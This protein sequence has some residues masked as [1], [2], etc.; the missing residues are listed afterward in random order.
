MYY[1]VIFLLLSLIAV[2][3]FY[4][5]STKNYTIFKALAFLLLFLTSGLRYE[6]AVDWVNYKRFF[7]NVDY[8][9]NIFNYGFTGFFIKYPNEPLFTLLNSLVRTFTDNVQVLFFFISLITTTLLF[10][11]L[12]YFTE[13]KYFFFSVML[14]YVLIFFILDM[15]GIRQCIALNI[16]F[17]AFKPLSESKLIRY[18]F[19]VILASMFHISAFIFIFGPLF[20]KKINISIIISLFIIGMIVFIVRIQWMV[21]FIQSL[22]PLFSNSDIY[23][24]ILAYTTSESIVSKARPIFIMLFVNS[25][26]YLFYLV[27]RKKYID[28]GSISTIFDNLF[29]MYILTTLFLW[30]ISDFG[31]RIGLYF[32]LG[33]IIS[34]PF[35]NEF[36]KKTSRFFIVCFIIFYCF[37]NARPYILENRSVISYNPYQ[38]YLIYEI[39]NIES[40]GPHRLNVYLN[41]IKEK[42]KK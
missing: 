28:K 32:T 33:L 14:Y 15:S 24:K 13:R 37:I 1:G 12:H 11:S 16:I 36:F 26:L 3:C 2:Y 18:C 39:F 27:G 30:E 42:Q 31:V 41:D 20:R 5:P 23:L 21:S 8:I 17:Y 38:N 29:T 34:L 9:Y 19:L 4:I 7:E 22:Y 35:I 25:I 10:K 6:T 40:T